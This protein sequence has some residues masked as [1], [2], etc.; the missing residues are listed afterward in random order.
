M[1]TTLFEKIWESHTVGME[2]GR[3]ILYI[4]R[5]L[6]HEITSAQAFEGLRQEKRPLRKPGAVMAVIDH[7]VPT[8][9]QRG[10]IEDPIAAKQIETLRKN[11]PEFGVTLF[12][13]TDERFDAAFA[14]LFRRVE[15]AVA[16]TDDTP[17]SLFVLNRLLRAV[18][19]GGAEYGLPMH[20][21][22]VVLNRS[23]N[24]LAFERYVER[25]RIFPILTI[26][27]SAELAALRQFHRT[28]FSLQSP[29]PHLERVTDGLLKTAELLRGEP[30][31]LYPVMPLE[32]DEIW[33]L[34]PPASLTN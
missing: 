15:G 6:I 28:L 22:G 34:P 20:I 26:P 17:E 21:V 7:N 16:V 27:E 29:P 8:I 9:N 3:T 5:H 4:D 30:L 18:L 24:P 25:T 31:N 12:D 33:R 23:V 1:A 10:P 14:P 32:D 13:V 2:G 11:A 19:I